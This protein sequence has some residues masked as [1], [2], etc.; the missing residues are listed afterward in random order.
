MTRL[1]DQVLKKFEKSDQARGQKAEGDRGGNGHTS[2]HISLDGCRRFHQQVVALNKH[3]SN[4]Q[5]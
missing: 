5:S 2:L 3:E 4:A 1:H